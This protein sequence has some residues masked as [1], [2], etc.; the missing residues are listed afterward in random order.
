MKDYSW[1]AETLIFLVCAA[2]FVWG[3]SALVGA[4]N[5][6]QEIECQ[7]YGAEW[8][9]KEYKPRGE[10]DCVSDKTGEGRWLN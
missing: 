8:H 3:V 1:I 6:R 9:V 5:A 10:P 7:K 2:L 4:S